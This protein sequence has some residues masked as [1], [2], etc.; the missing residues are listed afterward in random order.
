MFS[1]QPDNYIIVYD[2]N[3]G[4]EKRMTFSSSAA[5][6]ASRYNNSVVYVEDLD[7]VLLFSGMLVR[8]ESFAT[9]LWLYDLNTNTWEKVEP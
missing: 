5:F 7:R 6:P 9:D 3:T 4:N 2:L 8:G 1:R